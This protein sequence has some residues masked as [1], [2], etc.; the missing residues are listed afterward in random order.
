VIQIPDRNNVRTI[1]FRPWI[2]R[3]YSIMTAIAAESNAYDGSHKET[4]KGLL[5]LD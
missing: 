3:H 5:M 1:D 4:G 2:L